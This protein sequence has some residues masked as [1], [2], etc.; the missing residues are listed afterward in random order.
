MRAP[1]TTV[2]GVGVAGQC[3]KTP[4]D[5]LVRWSIKNMENGNWNWNM[6]QGWS[7][8]VFED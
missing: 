6:L 5:K 4:G 1:R 8:H 3:R 7:V 2:Q